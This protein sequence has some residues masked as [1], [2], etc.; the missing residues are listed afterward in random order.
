[1]L[2]NRGL[3]CIINCLCLLRLIFTSVGVI[4]RGIRAHTMQ[5][6]LLTLSSENQ[7]VGV[8][9]KSGRTNQSQGQFL[10]SPSACFLLPTLTIK[11]SLDHKHWS[12]KWNL[13]SAFNAVDLIFS[14]LL[15]RTLTQLL[16][17]TSLYIAFSTLYSSVTQ[18]SIEVC[19]CN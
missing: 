5:P 6:P 16:E 8:T 2:Y 10:C 1:M 9:S 14:T 17:K 3:T 13:N 18:Q 4:S 19:I 15:I 11:F 7:I 12:H